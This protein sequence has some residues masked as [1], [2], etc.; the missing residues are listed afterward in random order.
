MA[1]FPRRVYPERM[2]NRYTTV[3][4]LTD[5]LDNTYCRYKGEVVYVRV[6]DQDLLALLDI[7]S[8]ETR[9]KIDPHDPEFDISSIEIGYFNHRDNHGK[10]HVVRSVRGPEKSW[11][12]ALSR[13]QIN[14][15]SI[16]N[17]PCKICVENDVWTSQGFTEML[18]DTRMT[19]EDGLN[20]LVFCNEIAINRDIALQ[21]TATGIVNVYHSGTPLGWITPKSD[22]I[23]VVD[24]K[25][26]WVARDELSSMGLSVS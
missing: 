19:L 3:K 11:K 18:K 4:D 8:I 17:N 5:R 20:H 16:D 7:V 22:K 12:S 14:W 21:K 10:F 26:A 9:Y 2:P 6:M 23:T 13:G 1:T 15:R 24:R 25:I